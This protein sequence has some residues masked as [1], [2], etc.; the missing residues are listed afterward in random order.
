[1]HEFLTDNRDE[2]IERCRGKVSARLHRQATEEQLC[3]GVPLFL[4]QLIHTLIAEDAGVDDVAVRIS[5]PS[6]GDTLDLSEIG[7][8]AA[9]HGKTLQAL[10]FTVEQVVHD[11][12]DLCQ[13]ITELAQEKESPFQVEEFRTLNR[14]LD[15]AIADAVAEFSSRQS[16][17]EAKR[18]ASEAN[19]RL[20]FLVHDLRN[21]LEAT[22]LSVRAIELGGLP[23]SGAT[24]SMLK[25][26]LASLR[27]LVDS[28]IAEACAARDP[29]LT[30]SR[31]PL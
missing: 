27:N 9:A 23:L 10:G 6:G 17:V 31:P 5:G 20:E 29:L 2:L 7:I 4:E 15:N 25:R 3:Q 28:S 30:S 26:N 1:M 12:G 8:A 22:D 24:D 16:S 18:M 14:C 11:Y 19:D 13:A 21:A